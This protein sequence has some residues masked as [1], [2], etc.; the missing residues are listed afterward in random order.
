MQY[1]NDFRIP[2]EICVT[3]NVQTRAVADFKDHP[4]RL[5]YDEGLVVTLNTD[6]RLMSGTTLT[7]EYEH[8]A[9]HL[10]FTFDELARVAQ[11]GAFFEAERVDGSERAGVNLGAL[12]VQLAFDAIGER[13]PVV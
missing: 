11:Q 5:Y 8:A 4:V 10:D 12:E 1:V 6:N 2:L 7:E 9:R 3:S 13:G